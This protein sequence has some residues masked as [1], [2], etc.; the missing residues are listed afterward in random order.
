MLY[1][2]MLIIFVVLIVGP[3]VARNYIT[4]LGSSLP[5][6]LMQPTGQ[7]NNDTQNSLKTG[8]FIN[9]MHSGGQASAT[10]NNGGG[11]GGGAASSA[12]SNTDNPLSG[13]LTGRA[14]LPTAL[15]LMA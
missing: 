5:L 10:G 14:I 11:G 4:N 1:F 6:N 2:V 3:I 12:A 9:G 8:N 15:A 7:N 13:L